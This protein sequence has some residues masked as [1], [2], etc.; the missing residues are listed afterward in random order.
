MCPSPWIGNVGRKSTK[1]KVFLWFPYRT[2]EN[3]NKKSKLIKNRITT[4]RKHSFGRSS[5]WTKGNERRILFLRRRGESRE[6]ST[7][8]TLSFSIFSSARFAWAV[9]RVTV[10]DLIHI[11]T[12]DGNSCDW[13]MRW[14]EKD[15]H[16]CVV[17]SVKVR[18][19]VLMWEFSKDQKRLG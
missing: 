19:N 16:Q 11:Y 4:T 8:V 18:R 6:L 5:W 10:D 17:C 2:M 1:T 14:R 9:L 7:T 3:V 15:K 12:R 13:C